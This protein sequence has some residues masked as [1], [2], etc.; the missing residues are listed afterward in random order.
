MAEAL[1]A[2]RY[3]CGLKS[4]ER[5][6]GRNVDVKYHKGESQG[7]GAPILCKLCPGLWLTPNHVCSREYTR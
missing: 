3:F 1:I 7:L 6:L 4:Q 5:M 2:N